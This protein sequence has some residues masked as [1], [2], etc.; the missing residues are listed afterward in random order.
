MVIK[1]SQKSYVFPRVPLNISLPKDYPDI[2][3][4]SNVTVIPEIN[5]YR[6]N[7]NELELWGSYQLFISYQKAQPG[8]DE[9]PEELRELECDEFFSHL[10]LQADGLFRDEE[11]LSAQKASEL[12]TVQFTRTFHT[13][14]S[15]DFISRPRLFKPLIIVERVDVKSK[16]NRSIKGE[17]VL[18]MINKP[19]RGPW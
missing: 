18:G 15:T 6:Y 8:A 7:R 1:E 16:D 4:I 17:L 2:G 3:E 9:E 12:Y 10:K 13:Y 19:R 14:V 11:Q 5:D